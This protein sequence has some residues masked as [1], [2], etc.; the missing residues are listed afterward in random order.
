V[1]SIFLIF[2]ESEKI[3]G[4]SAGTWAGLHKLTGRK[5]ISDT[6]LLFKHILFKIKI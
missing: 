6:G 4:H 5:I 3:D 2:S 1:F